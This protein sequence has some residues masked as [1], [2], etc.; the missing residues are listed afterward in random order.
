MK[1]TSLSKKGK[2]IS[3]ILMEKIYA[4]FQRHRNAKCGEGYISNFK[5]CLEMLQGWIHMA[6]K[7]NTC[8][9]RQNECEKV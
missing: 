9:K 6:D 4:K 5:M 2:K 7:Q 8:Q 3:Q 1:L